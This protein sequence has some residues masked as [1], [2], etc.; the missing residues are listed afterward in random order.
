M[1]VIQ[2]KQTWVTKSLLSKEGLSLDPLLQPDECRKTLFSIK[3]Y[4]GEAGGGRL[5]TS[6]WLL[7]ARLLGQRAEEWGL[8]GGSKAD[9]RGTFVWLPCCFCFSLQQSRKFEMNLKNDCNMIFTCTQFHCTSLHNQMGKQCICAG[10]CLWYCEDVALDDGP[11]Y[12]SS[13]SFILMLPRL[14]N[15]INLN[16]ITSPIAPELFA[17]SILIIWQSTDP[18]ISPY[19]HEFRK[20]FQHGPQ[21]VEWLVRWNIL[22]TTFTEEGSCPFVYLNLVMN[23]W[24]FQAISAKMIFRQKVNDDNMINNTWYEKWFCLI[25]I[26]QCYSSE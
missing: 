12:F 18:N 9:G 16:Q 17:W 22:T 10:N 25:I 11:M 20:C 13:T 19:L 3:D 23:I 24:S 2:S 4:G 7:A 15:R 6:L 1:S 26:R 5:P 14:W 21:T 8:G